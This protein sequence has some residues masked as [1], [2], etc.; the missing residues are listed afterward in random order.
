MGD[1]SAQ[2]WG[3]EGHRTGVASSEPVR[4][5]LQTADVQRQHPEGA[6]GD[7]GVLRRPLLRAGGTFPEG[8]AAAVGE[9]QPGGSQTGRRLQ[10]VE[11]K[12]QTLTCLLVQML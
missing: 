1:R 6:G 2:L 12:P 8:R 7:L 3:G 11:E 10:H 9:D 5:E 4:P